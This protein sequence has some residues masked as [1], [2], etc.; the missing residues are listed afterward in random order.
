MIREKY[1]DLVW[2]TCKSQGILSSRYVTVATLRIILPNCIK[3]DAIR[4]KGPTIQKIDFRTMRDSIFI[5]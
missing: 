4:E 3:C 5:N 1:D 2:K